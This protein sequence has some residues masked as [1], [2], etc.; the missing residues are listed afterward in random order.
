M[1]RTAE[2]EAKAR[3]HPLGG[4]GWGTEPGR[5][6]PPENAPR[7]DGSGHV[8]VRAR[9]CKHVGGHASG[10]LVR[11]AKG[12]V[13]S[14]RRLLAGRMAAGANGPPAWRGGPVVAEAVAQGPHPTRLRCGM[15]AG[16]RGGAF[17]TS[18][19]GPCCP[20]SVGIRCLSRGIGPRGRGKATKALVRGSLYD[21][22]PQSFE[23]IG[24]VGRRQCEH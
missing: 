3:G 12:W 11:D 17:A 7:D 24:L 18:R 5:Q 15:T 4:S 8:C 20:G 13:E 2:P 22:P 14:E 10:P 1:L 16:L 19:D 23:R 9:E 6:Q 21:V